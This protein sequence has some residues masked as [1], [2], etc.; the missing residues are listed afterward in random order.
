V[1]LEVK[2][3]QNY[4]NQFNSTNLQ[5]TLVS[6]KVKSLFF[7][8]F[9]KETR[10]RNFGARFKIFQEI[11]SSGGSFVL[12]IIECEVAENRMGEI[13]KYYQ[14]AAEQGIKEAYIFTKSISN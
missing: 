13:F 2:S 3:N 14:I 4:P 9:K 7:C 5:Q 10:K 1:N 6:K 12:A 11:I 8:F